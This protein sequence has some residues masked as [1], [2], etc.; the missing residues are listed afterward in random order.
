MAKDL[1]AVLG[2]SK[3]A[4]PEEIKSA[5]RKKSKEWHPDKHKGD[6]A[7]EDK[8]KE[9]N[10][11]YEILGDAQKKQQYD[12]FGTT[13]NMGGGGGGFGGFD[14]SGFQ[15]GADAFSDLG[16]IFGSFFGGQKEGGRDPN[17]GDNREV[18]III[19]LQE[20]LH[21][22]QHPIDLRRLN[23]CSTCTGSGAEPGSK[24][25]KC[26]TCGGTGQVTRSV[27][28]F[29]G[30]IQQRSVCNS[31]GGS[32]TIPEKKCHT[33]R[34]EGR[35]ADTVRVTIDIPAGIDN[36]QALRISK[37]GDSGRRG[38]PAGDLYVRIRVRPDARFERQGMDIRSTV[39]IP[40][41]D[42]ILGGEV[43]V[44]TVDGTST[45]SIPEGTQP[46]QIFRIK[47]KGLPELGRTSHIGDHYVV[48][49]VEI[50]KKL[51]KAERKILEE[52]KSA[53]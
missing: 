40:A 44:D 2:L 45:L 24:V 51:S 19:T 28:S 35:I 15:N 41:V 37:Q 47:G 34:G 12:Q 23:T 32:G 43:D 29:F 6:K 9:I 21:G 36:G 31:C 1:Y 7:A 25:I 14:F 38:G 18:E 8:F 16:D 17:Q 26:D 10:E 48:V 22:V 30:Q 3:G 50:P 49:N 20:V 27:H 4:T 53:R 5:Y 46:G 52:W 42:A 11:A 33:C 13:G 39:A